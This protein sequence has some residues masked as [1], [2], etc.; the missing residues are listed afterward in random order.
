MDDMTTVS[1]NL[2]LIGGMVLGIILFCWLV[3]KYVYDRCK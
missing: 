1:E 3:R 2:K